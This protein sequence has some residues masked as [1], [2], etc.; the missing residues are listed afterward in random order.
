LRKKWSAPGFQ[1]VFYF[2]EIEYLPIEN[3]A[4][5]AGFIPHRLIGVGRCIED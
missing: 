4:I 2:L 1:V 3:N 5:A